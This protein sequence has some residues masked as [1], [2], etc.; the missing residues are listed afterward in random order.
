M[1]AEIIAIGTELL[2]GHTVNT[3]ASYISKKMS[4]LGI[5]VYYHSTVGDNVERLSGLVQKALS[6]SDII[7]TTGGLGPTVDDITIRTVSKAIGKELVFDKHVAGEIK[8]YFIRQRLP[9]PKDS[10][11]QAF[12]PRGC[13][14]FEN[15]VG[16][17]PG[18]IIPHKGKKIICLPG[19]PGELQPIM[20]K[21]IVPH[22]KKT[23][24]KKEIIHSKSIRLI[25]LPEA[26]INAK[27]KDL[28]TL[29]GSA[30]VGIYVHLGEAELKITAKAKSEKACKANIEKIESKI[31]KRL[32][33]FIYGI[34]DETLESAVGK[35]LLKFRKTLG[36][37]ESCTGGLIS[38][39]VTNV[40]GSSEYFKMGLIAYSN[41]AKISELG[42]SP[43]LLRTA[44]A[45]SSAAAASMAKGIKRIAG[46]HMGLAVTGIAGPRDGTNKKPVGLV[47]MALATPGKLFSK[48]FY[49]RGK[50][51][52]IKHLASQA[53]LNLIRK[54]LLK[55][56]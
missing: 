12:I 43:K 1:K 48:K 20:E 25:G 10:L 15:T 30:T 47:Y 51:T 14:W 36:I 42:V 38:S 4:G 23:L 34:D 3:N 7:F 8:E 18:L 35:L 16:T 28:L 54:Y 31:R 29:G 40:S 27:V 52:D 37:A 39:R 2:L 26:A 11:R 33:K 6:R 21:Y 22:L 5:D 49:F 9:T 44:G 50:R 17:A 46:T 13:M 19:P 24:T 45:V 55:I 53:A 41:D 32:G 56:N